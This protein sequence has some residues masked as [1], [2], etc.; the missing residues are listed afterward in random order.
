MRLDLRFTNRSLDELWCQAV[1]M[2]SFKVNEKI[3]A[4]L[5][6]LDKKMTGSIRNIIQSGIWTGERGEKLLLATQNSI[7][8]D[9]LLV[10]GLGEEVK[11][12]LQLLK[13]EIENVGNALV[14]LGVNELSIEIP[15]V[16]GIDAGY[17]QYIETAV[18]NITDIYMQKYLDV[19]DFILKLYVVIDNGCVKDISRIAE[20]LRGSFPALSDISIILDKSQACQQANVAEMAA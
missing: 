16:T 12:S 7:K 5:D 14:K 8:A 15:G 19:P 18:K 2:L 10:Y 13:S 6:H 20:N 9:K 4:P 11:Y 17:D 1:V 3:A